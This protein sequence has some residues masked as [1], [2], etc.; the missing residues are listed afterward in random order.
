MN[1]YLRAYYGTDGGSFPQVLFVCH[2]AERQRFLEREVSKK[3]LMALFAVCQFDQAME[4][5][6]QS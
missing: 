1:A 5:L 4:V 6:C 2:S 3:S